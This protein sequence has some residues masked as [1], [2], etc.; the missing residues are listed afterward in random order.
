M[1]TITVTD[2]RIEQADTRSSFTSYL[3]STKQGNSVRRRYS[4]FQWLYQRLRTEVPGAIVPIIPHT[5]TLMSAKKFNLEFIEERRRLLQDFLLDI[6]QHAEL[7]RAPS[8]TPFMLLELGK[9]F[10]EGKKKVELKIPTIFADAG[11]KSES[12]GISGSLA[13]PQLVS[14]TK[15]ITNF[16]AKVKMTATAQELLTSQDES[17]VLALSNYIADIQ[18][19]VKALTKASEALLKS[20]SSTAAAY[21]ELGV[22]IGLW[23]TT[24]MQQIESQSDDEKD[25]MSQMINFSDEMSSLLEKKHKEDEFLFGHTITKLTNTV[26]AFEISLEQ[27]KLIQIDYTQIQNSLIEKNCALEK[28]QKNLK[29]PEVTDKLA[30]E[31]VELESRIEK[32]K[33]RFEEVTKRVIRDGEKY[34]P[35][36]AQMLQNSFLMLAKTKIAYTTRINEISQ[37]LISD[38]EGASLPGVDSNGEDSHRP[39]PPPSAP[40]EPPSDDE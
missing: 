21:G 3:V 18:G 5:R 11:S 9:D 7:C 34:K 10:D 25:A 13:Q 36:L 22:P 14:A 28:A 26:A 27:R 23:R 2:P 35:K 6:A 1:V 20:T 24:L 30:S 17:R 40:P 32:E 39:H 19:H 16:L 4:D 33:E 29:P 37:R 12:G 15:G 31:R 8:M 38:L